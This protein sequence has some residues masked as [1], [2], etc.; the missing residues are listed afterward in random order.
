MAH[1]VCVLGVGSCSLAQPSGGDAEACRGKWEWASSGLSPD[2]WEGI[3]FPWPGVSTKQPARAHRRRGV[4]EEEEGKAS[5]V[6]GE[7]ERRG[8]GTSY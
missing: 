1:W 5:V 8:S 7:G 4:E 3:P 6:Q 2:L